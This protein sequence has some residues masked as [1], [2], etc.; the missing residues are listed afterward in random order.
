MNQCCI[1]RKEAVRRYESGETSTDWEC[2]DNLTDE[3]I[4]RAVREDPDQELLTEDWFWRAQLVMPG[5]T[6]EMERLFFFP[7]CSNN[8]VYFPV[9]P[10]PRDKCESAVAFY[11]EAVGNRIPGQVRPT[12]VRTHIMIVPF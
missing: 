12:H 6:E 4:T 1:L 9:D 3:E 10:I 5:E 11:S 8:T 7:L 2:V